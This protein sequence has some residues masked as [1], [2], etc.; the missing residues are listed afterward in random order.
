MLPA[1]S[2]ESC[3]AWPSSRSAWA[4]AFTSSLAVELASS[5]SIFCTCIGH[6]LAKAVPLMKA[7]RARAVS[8]F[9]MGFSSRFVDD[10]RRS[11]MKPPKL[12]MR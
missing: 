3:S 10:P 9:F 12:R 8:S 5:A 6:E 7:V 11:G 4:W 2:P 1:W